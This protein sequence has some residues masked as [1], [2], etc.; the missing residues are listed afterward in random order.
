MAHQI[1]EVSGFV[2]M[3]SGV[4][5]RAVAFGFLKHDIESTERGA[6]A[7]LPKMHLE[8]SCIQSSMKVYVDEEDVSSRLHTSRIT[9]MSSR[10]AMLRSVREFLLEVQHG[11]GDRFGEDPG[12]VAVGRDIGT[13]VFPDAERKFFVTASPEVRARR[14]LAEFSQ[15]GVTASFQEVRD[16]IIERDRQDSQRVIAPLRKASD[17]IVINTDQLTPDEQA[18]IVLGYILER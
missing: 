13:V 12:V 15:T 6:A 4:M 3:D 5:Y 17:A 14:R 10:I 7:Y 1:A 18:A 2:F 16:A 8:V 9:E 11:F